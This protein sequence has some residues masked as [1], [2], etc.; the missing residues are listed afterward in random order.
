MATIYSQLTF[1]HDETSAND[2]QDLYAET[3][4]RELASEKIRK[5]VTSQVSGAH[6]CVVLTRINAVRSSGTVTLAAHVATNTVTINGIT[7][8]AVSGAPAAGQ[9]DISGGDTTGAASLVLAILANA[10]LAGMVTATSAGAVVTV[11]AIAPGAIGNAI[12][13]AISANGSVSAARTAGGT[14]GDTETYH[15]F[16]SSSTY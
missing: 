14:N 3:G 13:L 9:Y 11:T 1:S 8:T 10:T 2:Q 15:Y 4:L 12:T 7:L 16:G 6:P 5:F